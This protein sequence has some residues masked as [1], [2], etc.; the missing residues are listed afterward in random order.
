RAGHQHAEP[1][2]SE[3]SKH[4]QSAEQAGHRRWTQSLGPL[5]ARVINGGY[6][7]VLRQIPRNVLG[8]G[9]VPCDSDLG[10]AAC[11]TE[12]HAFL[13]RRSTAIA[14]TFHYVQVTARARTLA[15]SSLSDRVLAAGLNKDEG[16]IG[17]FFFRLDR[18]DALLFLRSHF[19][20]NYIA[21]IVAFALQLSI[22]GVIP[23]PRIHAHTP[24]AFALVALQDFSIFAQLVLV[25]RHDLVRRILG[26]KFDGDHLQ[27]E[28]TGGNIEVG[29]S[30]FGIA[31]F[32]WLA[33]RSR[34]DRE[35]RVLHVRITTHV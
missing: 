14:R 34:I 12:R 10:R 27:P 32:L 30:F 19:E 3:G 6:W 22:L 5:N 28:E 11:R 18:N 25:V 33:R 13:N 20:L 31:L 26:E 15:R 29:P 7:S 4:Q 24:A 2:N 8:L 21:G 16:E 23:V 17:A 1:K 9:T 35:A